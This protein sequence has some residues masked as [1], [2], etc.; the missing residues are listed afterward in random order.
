MKI[1]ERLKGWLTRNTP[2]C[3]GC[4]KVAPHGINPERFDREEKR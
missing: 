2:L 3:V 4:D 1:V